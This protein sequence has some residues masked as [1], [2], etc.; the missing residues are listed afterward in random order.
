MEEWRDIR[1]FE[2]RYQ[3]S[4]LGRVKSLAR[5]VASRGGTRLVRE[6]I[7]KLH[8]EPFYYSVGLNAGPDIAVR[9]RVHR[10][11]CEAFHPN[12]DGLPQVA[13]ADGDGYN[14][15]AENLRWATALENAYDK[16]KHGTLLTGEE[17]NLSVLG[18]REVR[19]IRATINSE[20]HN[21]AAF[22]GVDYNTVRDI[23]L[24]KRW[25]QLK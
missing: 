10:L 25:K 15:R 23:Y 8:R 12:P 20:M 2:G 6:R 11:V 17:C 22:L 7:L 5:R 13:H 21:L 9:K 18:P 1:G 4:S 19:H 16:F 24:D 14:N 3:V